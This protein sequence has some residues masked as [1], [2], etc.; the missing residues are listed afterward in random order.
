MCSRMNFTSVLLLMVL[1]RDVLRKDGTFVFRRIMC[2][3]P[4]LTRRLIAKE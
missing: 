1:R 2:M 3:W 4:K